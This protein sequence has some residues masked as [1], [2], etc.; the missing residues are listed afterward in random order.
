ERDPCFLSEWIGFDLPK[1]SKVQI[2]IYSPDGKV[3]YEYEE[4]LANGR[5]QLPID[6]SQLRGSGL[7]YYQ[8]TVDGNR[9]VKKMILMDWSGKIKNYTV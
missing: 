3:A 5:H 4:T 9:A 2:R 1:V 7:W 8:M 6:R